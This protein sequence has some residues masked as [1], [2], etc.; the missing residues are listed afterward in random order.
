MR[1]TLIKEQSKTMGR[2][3]YTQDGVTYRIKVKMRYDDHCGNGQNTF[4]ITGEIQRKSD[5]GKR[6]LEDTWGCIHEEIQKYF[7]ELGK[8]IKWHLTSSDEPMHYIA[9]TV[10][11]ASNRDHNGLLKGEKRQIKNGMTGLP[12]WILENTED[13]QQYVDSETKPEETTSSG[14]VPWCTDGEGKER[15]LDGA[16]SAAVWLEA[17]DKDLIDEGLEEKLK[18][19]LPQLMEEFRRNMESLGFTY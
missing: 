9:N 14:Y 3:T 13:L 6:W 11:L 19:R 15:D 4:S 10:Y 17:T 8:Y 2:K 7:P 12:C 16:R 1:S 18:K 5:N